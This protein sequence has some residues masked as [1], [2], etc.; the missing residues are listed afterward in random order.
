MA[1][2]A[3]APKLNNRKTVED[4]RLSVCSSCRC[5]IFKGQEYV[6][7]SVGLI[8]TTCEELDVKAKTNA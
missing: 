7:T 3:F 2:G 5:G 6:W 8:H 4:T 1:E